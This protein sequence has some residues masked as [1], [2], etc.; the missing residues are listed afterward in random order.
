MLEV[1]DAELVEMKRCKTRGL[2]CGAGG[3]QMWKEDEPGNK[4]INMERIDEALAVKPDVV[5][6]ACP[7]CMT[8]MT[9]GVKNRQQEE[10]VK[11]YDL[12]ELIAR[13]N[14]LL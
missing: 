5:A 6:A 8:M 1:L 9:D 13:A 14:D 12:A 10:Q 11:V 2:C 7:F 3:A 4:R